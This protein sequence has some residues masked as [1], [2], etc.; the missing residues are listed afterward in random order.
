MYSPASMTPSIS[1]PD[2]MPILLSMYTK[3]SVARLP[4][5]PFEYGHPPSPATEL[6]TTAT[7]R[8]IAAS[9]FTS[10]V[11]WVS[12]VWMARR[13]TGTRRITASTWGRREGCGGGNDGCGGGGGG[14]EGDGM[15]GV[16]WGEG[17]GDEGDGSGRERRAERGERGERGEGRLERKVGEAHPIICSIG[18]CLW[19]PILECKFSTTLSTGWDLFNSR[20]PTHTHTHTRCTVRTVGWFVTWTIYHYK[21]W[22]RV[23]T[24]GPIDAGVPTPFVSPSEIS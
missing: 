18:L 23:R 6:S 20:Q 9:T 4:V 15:R 21:Y 14:D 1:T 17:R 7:P 19:C 13:S 24:I 22:F 5:A 11:P 3:S 12:W 8:S 10:A 16:G 2:S